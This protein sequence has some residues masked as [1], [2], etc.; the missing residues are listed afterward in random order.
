MSKSRFS[1][2]SMLATLSFAILFGVMAA[3]PSAFAEDEEHAIKYRKSVMKSLG[4]H[5]GAT[6]AIV[7]GKAGQPGHLAGHVAAIVDISTIAKDLF[8]EGSDFG[9]TTVL[10]KVWD[11]P[12]AFKR[13]LRMFEAQAAAF[14]KAAGSGDMAAIG[15]AMGNLGKSCK[16]C[17]ENFREK[18]Q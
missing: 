18:K 2:L 1:R 4:G 7:G 15:A 17:H 10:A 12:D 3:A 11:E 13:E 9:E 8:P 14:G 16:S 6:A 5:M